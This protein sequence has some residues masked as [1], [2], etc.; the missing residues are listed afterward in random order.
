[1]WEARAK[2]RESEGNWRRAGC[3]RGWD[4]V[5]GDVKEGES[6]WVAEEGSRKI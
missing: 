4:R 6:D 5:L 1:M 2:D 3:F